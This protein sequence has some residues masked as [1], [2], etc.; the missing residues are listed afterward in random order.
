LPCEREKLPSVGR[1]S[2]WKDGGQSSLAAVGSEWRTE[3]RTERRREK[4]Y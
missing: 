4:V 2:F 3:R 1:L